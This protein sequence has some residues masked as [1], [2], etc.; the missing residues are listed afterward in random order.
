MATKK[1]KEIA[2][3]ELMV[4]FTITQLHLCYRKLALYPEEQ[5]A[6]KNLINKLQQIKWQ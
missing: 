2:D 3:G 6:I 1:K 4:G 5:E